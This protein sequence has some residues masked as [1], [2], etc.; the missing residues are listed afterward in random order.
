MNE[1]E[2]NKRIEQLQN[3]LVDVFLEKKYDCCFD[4]RAMQ[5]IGLL[6]SL[7]KKMQNKVKEIKKLQHE[8]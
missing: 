3:E 7:V 2:T 4:E 6:R 1:E 8:K 5:N